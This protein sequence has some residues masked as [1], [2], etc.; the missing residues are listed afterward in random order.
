M[1]VTL[2]TGGQRADSGQFITLRCRNPTQQSCAFSLCNPVHPVSA[3][4]C[5]AY[6]SHHTADRTPRATGCATASTREKCDE[7]TSR[8]PTS[9]CGLTKPTT[10]ALR[11]DVGQK[12]PTVF[13]D[14]C[15]LRITMRQVR[16]CGSLIAPRNDVG[17]RA[18]RNSGS[19]RSTI[20]S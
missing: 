11:C 5:V 14:F 3:G 13:D 2:E 1:V 17:G 20:F 9:R 10:S 19:P 15:C 6:Q 18:C 8:G 12:V 4:R 16:L 7:V